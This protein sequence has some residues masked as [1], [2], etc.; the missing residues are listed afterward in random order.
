LPA[1]VCENIFSVCDAGDKKMIV[2]MADPPRPKVSPSNIKEVLLEW[3][4]IW[5]WRSL[6]FLG[7]DH[8][9][10]EAISAGTCIAVS[11]GSYI[12]E[13][14]TDLCSAAFIL[15]CTEGRGGIVESF[16]EQMSVACAYRGKLLGLM[17]I[18]LIILA[19]NK[20]RPNL[21][22]S[23]D[24]YSDCLGA[25]DKVATLPQN[26]IPTRCRHSDILKN[27]MLHANNLTFDI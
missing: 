16:P 23:V 26:R 6:H 17:A 13:H 27:I 15:E 20:V 9:L 8:W 21:G 12:K 19:A 22:G 25:L 10:E 5:I 7:E 3:G 2:S 1:G 24:V 4:N 18:H 11:D 14:Y